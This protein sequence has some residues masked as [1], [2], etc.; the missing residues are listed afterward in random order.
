MRHP[1]PPADLHP[2]VNTVNFVLDLAPVLQ[3]KLVNLNSYSI[4]Y[5]CEFNCRN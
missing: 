3:I 1:L 2:T 4:T 5:G